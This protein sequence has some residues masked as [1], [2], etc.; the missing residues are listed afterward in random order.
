MKTEV[1]KEILNLDHGEYYTVPE[2]DYGKANI[3]RLHDY[4]ILFEIPTFGGEP[5]YVGSYQLLILD[6][7]IKKIDSW[8]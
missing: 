1:R 4:Y 3:Y 5:R 6:E 7:M 2:S 8:T